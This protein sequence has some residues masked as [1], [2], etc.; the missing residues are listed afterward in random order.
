MRQADEFKFN[1]LTYCVGDAECV[2]D[3]IN[4]PALAPFAD[5]AID[6]LN[7]LSKLL[8]K[9]GRGYSDIISFAFWCRRSALAKEKQRYE[10]IGLRLGR[11]VVMHST[12]SNVPVNFAFSFAAGL[13]AGNKNLVRLPAKPFPQVEI[14]TEA[15]NELLA[16]GYKAMRPYVVMVKFPPVKAIT[17]AFSSICDTRVIWGG[18]ATIA[19]IRQSPLPPRAN[20]IAFADRHSLCVIDAS[21]YLAAGDKARIASDF[22]ND[23]Y[24]TDQNAC[25]SPRAVVW[26]AADDETAEKAKAEFWRELYALAKPKYELKPVQAVGKLHAA[27]KAAALL[28]EVDIKMEPEP[29]A[30]I[31]RLKVNKLTGDLMRFKYNSGFFFE[32]TARSLDEILPLAS[33]PCQTLLYFGV[34]TGEIEAFVKKNAPRGIDR[35]VPIGRS[36][37]FALRWDGYDLVLTMSRVISV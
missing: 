12:P 15:V 18:D 34:D 6:F 16:G 11:G 21:A 30:L 33:L 4:A 9:K 25:T 29:D 8:M 35:A 1:E 10:N 5:E 24:F 2:I 31:T 37:D 22:Y 23:T 3:L 17:D 14:I 28:R 26:L 27:C 36:M 19:E 13:I 20:E 7:E 32:Y